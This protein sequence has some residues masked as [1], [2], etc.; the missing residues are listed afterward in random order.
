MVEVGVATLIA[1]SWLEPLWLALVQT[2]DKPLNHWNLNSVL[3]TSFPR[4]ERQYLV[5]DQF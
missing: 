5:G 2:L 4:H 3:A 1:A